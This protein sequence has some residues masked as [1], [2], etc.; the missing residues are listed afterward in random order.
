MSR[1]PKGAPNFLVQSEARNHPTR[2]DY[3]QIEYRVLRRFSTKQ[4][5]Y[6]KLLPFWLAKLLYRLGFKKF[7]YRKLY[8]G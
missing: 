8:G 2:L 3:E 1:K 6:R 5:W 4:P 7:L